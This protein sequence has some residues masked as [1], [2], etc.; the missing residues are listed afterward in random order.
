ML[1]FYL[2]LIFNNNVSEL[3]IDANMEIS[4]KILPPE[5]A[6]DSLNNE[7]MRKKIDFLKSSEFNNQSLLL[8]L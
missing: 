3:E 5:N 2:F 1:I 6:K 8:Y 7:Q 4:S